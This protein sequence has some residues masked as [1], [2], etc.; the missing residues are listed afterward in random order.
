[1]KYSAHLHYKTLTGKFEPFT[2]EH[3]LPQAE[4][5]IGVL[6]FV[7]EASSFIAAAH[8]IALCKNVVEVFGSKT[9]REAVKVTE[10]STRYTI[11]NDDNAVGRLII[12]LDHPNSKII[13][14]D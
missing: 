9:K 2:G 3:T 13:F 10:E 8:K 7:V 6:E 1:M 4:Q 11:S 14:I 12:S 5:N